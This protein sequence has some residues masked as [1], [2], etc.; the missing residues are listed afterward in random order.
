MKLLTISLLALSLSGISAYAQTDTGAVKINLGTADK[1]A[2]LGGSG[3][4]NVSAH[5]FIIGDVGS[6]PTATVKG[7]K[8]AQ[9]KGKL[10]LKSSPVTAKAQTA[11]TKAY[12]Q[13]ASAHCGTTLTGVNLGGMK[14]IPGVYCFAAAAQLTGT[15]KLDAQGDSNAQW[16]FQ[17]ATTLTTAP[18]SKVVVNLTGK[19]ARGCNVY[20]QVGSSATVGKGSIF[21][22]K[23]LALTSVTLDGGTLRGK[24]LARSGAISISAPET[25]DGPQCVNDDTTDSDD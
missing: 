21:V 8:P 11:L 24:A 2:V 10:Y 1:F 23:M 15:L 6:A 9:V 17:I 25:V 16:I 19:G 5:T 12:D 7:L 14:L 3:I 18:N 22:G 13:A 4:T 20:W